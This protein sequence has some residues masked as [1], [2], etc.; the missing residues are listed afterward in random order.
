[1]SLMR[2]ASSGSKGSQ[3]LL[4][5]PCHGVTG[6][7]LM[8]QTNGYNASQR[9]FSNGRFKVARSVCEVKQAELLHY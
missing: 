2:R 1:L 3:I 6:A 5:I 4:G 7:V 9:M 8:D